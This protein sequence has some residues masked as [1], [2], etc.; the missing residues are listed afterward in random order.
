MI[1]EFHK[2]KLLDNNMF[3]ISLMEEF[4][5]YD[6]NI[7]VSDDVKNAY[8]IFINDFC[9]MVSSY[10][11]KYLRDHCDDREKA[12]FQMQLTRSDEAF[13][14]LVLICHYE[15]RVEDAKLIQQVGFQSWNEDRLKGKSGKHEIQTNRDIYVT[16]FNKITQHRS[17]QAA[18]DYWC[19]IFFDKYFE[20]KPAMSKSNRKELIPSVNL[21]S[22]PVPTS[23]D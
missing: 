3:D 8:F 2:E 19:N 11:K 23:F 16:M 13:T 17:N 18:Y 4:Y 20:L 5:K 15:K 14:Y 12:T 9:T 1:L 22:V 7:E 10:W 6:A 21:I